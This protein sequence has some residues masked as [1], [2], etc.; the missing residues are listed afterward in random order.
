MQ[1]N[2]LST[3]R[4]PLHALARK[5][6]GEVRWLNSRLKAGRIDKN[7]YYDS[8]AELIIQQTLSNS[9]NSICVDVECHIQ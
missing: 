4:R 9:D 8:L 3:M 5:L 7:S 2:A 1:L 6:L